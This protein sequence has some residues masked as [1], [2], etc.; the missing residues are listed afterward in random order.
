[1]ATNDSRYAARGVSA[2]KGEVHAA[3]DKLDQGVF[4]GAFCK[5]VPDVLTGDPN[6]CNLIHADGSGTKSL[7][8]Y[9]HYKQTGDASVF[10]GI[11]QDSI[12]MNLDDLLCVGATGPILINSTVNRNARN[13]PGEALA[14]LIGGTEDF[15]Q[16]LRDYGVDI[17]SGGGETADVGDILG[18]VTVDSCAVAVMERDRV[19]TGEKIVPGLAIIGMSSHGQAS[20]EDFANSGIGSNGL[21]SA[22]HE[23][24]A[25]YYREQYPETYDKATDESL[26]YCGPYRLSDTLPGSDM[27][28]GQA[29]LSPTRTYAPVIAKL[30]DEHGDDVRG[31]VHCSGGGQGKCLRFGRGVHFIKDALMPYPPIFAAIQETSQS[32]WQEMYQVFNMGHRMELYCLPERTDAL[33]AV[34]RSFGIEAQVIGRTEPSQRKDDGN[35][36]SLTHAGE[37][38][39]YAL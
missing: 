30:L 8:A 35:H 4:P 38:L 36:L 27:T 7:I 6:K 28:V 29:L 33:L 22:R 16:K 17:V 13:F 5:V 9:L 11:A 26:V 1:M 24:L 23:L 18:T 14:E 25:P 19:I 15:L 2:T 10:R 32:T 37:V 12:V 31:L 3:V 21:T 39:S 20:Y 34:V